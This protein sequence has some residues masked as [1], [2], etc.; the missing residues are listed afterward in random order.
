MVCYFVKVSFLYTDVPWASHYTK[1]PA[2][3]LLVQFVQAN[4]TDQSAVLLAFCGGNR[5]KIGGFPLENN[6]NA[7]KAS[8]SCIV[9]LI[10]VIS[11]YMGK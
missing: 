3:Q 9:Q 7:E 1:T 6:S 11:I 5:P 2:I 4:S 8:M 10:T